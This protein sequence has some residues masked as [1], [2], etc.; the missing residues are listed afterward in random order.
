MQYPSLYGIV[1]R[2]Q[3]TVA[4]VLGPNSLNIAFR[5][6]LTGDKWTQWLNL[7]SRLMEVQ[8]S[9][10]QDF[11]RWNLTTSGVFSVKSMYLDFMNGH[12][13]FL[14][15]YIWKIKVPLKI[16]IFMWFLHRKVILTKDNLLKRNWQGNKSCVFCDKDES[17][18]HLFFECPL[19]KIIWR[20]VHM[21]FGIPPPRNVSNMFGNWLTGLDKH[22]VKN[23]RIGACAIV[24]A[25]W[26]SRNDHVFNKPKAPSFLQVI[27]MATHWI[28]TWSY[29][30]PLEQR[31]VMDSGCNRL[32][33]VARDLFNQ[34]G[35]RRD[36][37]ISFS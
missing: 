33:T 36:N 35:W 2:K 26:N 34:F 11:F 19:A 28:R 9:S 10:D 16:R 6:N 32:E 37:R 8:L 22:V 4:T 12:T 5:R 31:D 23:V 7:V 1:Q 17:I 18:N 13:I 3:V 14:K 20:I 15:K 21:T 29:L 24:W 27:P 25:L 30:Q